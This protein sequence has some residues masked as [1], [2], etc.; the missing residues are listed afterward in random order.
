MPDAIEMILKAWG[1]LA[2]A[3]TL[4]VVSVHAVEAP[5]SPT[6]CKHKQLKDVQGHP[7]KHKFK[8]Y[9]TFMIAVLVRNW[10]RA[11]HSLPTS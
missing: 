1:D 2:G 6:P 7:P 8:K 3:V 5:L 10:A 9:Y 11:L 4:L